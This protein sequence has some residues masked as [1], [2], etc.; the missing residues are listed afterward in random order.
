MFTLFALWSTTLS[1]HRKNS[2]NAVSAL[3][4]LWN[5]ESNGQSWMSK[6]G[7]L[8]QKYSFSEGLQQLNKICNPE[9]AKAEAPQIHARRHI[10]N[11]GSVAIVKMN[12]KYAHWKCHITLKVII[13]WTTEGG[14]I[15]IVWRGIGDG[16]PHH[17]IFP[18]FFLRKK[19]NSMNDWLNER[20][21]LPRRR[22]LVGFEKSS[23]FKFSRKQFWIFQRVA[24]PLFL[25]KFSFSTDL[26]F[27]ILQIIQ[28]QLPCLV[29][30]CCSFRRW[31]QC[32]RWKLLQDIASFS[33]V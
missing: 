26:G 13:R 9:R 30:L 12:K 31:G 19:E 8:V 16:Q 6:R 10:E 32:S 15:V 18:R 28:K 2:S 5:Y 29:V 4:F 24:F 22:S 33:P 20:M 23:K 7:A 21:A 3:L 14:E 17:Q 25:N 11:D 27:D 1:Q